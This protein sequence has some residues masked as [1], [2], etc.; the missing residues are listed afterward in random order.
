[1]RGIA[2]DGTNVL[3]VYESV[4]EAVQRA[5]AGEGCRLHRSAALS[6]PRARWRGRRQPRPLR[7]IAEREAWEQFCPID[8]YHRF[9]ESAG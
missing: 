8:T 4:K 1:M 5:R 7:D 2:V 3:A 6:L 9:L